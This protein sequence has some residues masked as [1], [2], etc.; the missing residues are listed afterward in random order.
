MAVHKVHVSHKLR[1]FRG[2]VWCTHCGRWA[3]KN[4]HLMAAACSPTTQAGRDAFSRIHRGLPPHPALRWP[5]DALPAELPRS[6][7]LSLKDMA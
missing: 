4:P 1:A 3:T 7:G 2:V 6:F 5:F